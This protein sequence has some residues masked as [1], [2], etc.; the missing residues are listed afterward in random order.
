MR[1]GLVVGAEQERIR[2]CEIIYPCV[3]VWSDIR[4][5]FVRFVSEGALT[6]LLALGEL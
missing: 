6:D 5:R 3:R 1:E 4:E 2:I